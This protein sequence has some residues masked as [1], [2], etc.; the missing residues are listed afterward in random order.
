MEL[1]LILDF[2]SHS[3]LYN[4]RGLPLVTRRPVESARL[5]NCVEPDCAELEDCTPRRCFD[6]ERCRDRER[7][8]RSRDRLE[9][10]LSGRPMSNWVEVLVLSTLVSEGI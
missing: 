1:F 4:N 3:N 6:R 2:E 9:Y 10:R 7:D 8:L 5:L